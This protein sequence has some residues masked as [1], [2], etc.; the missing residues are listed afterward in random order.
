MLFLARGDTKA[1]QGGVVAGTYGTRGTFRGVNGFCFDAS[2]TV[3]VKNET[4][5]DQEAKKIMVKDVEEG[6]LIGT[7]DLKKS[8]LNSSA[9]I[10]TRVIDVDIFGGNWKAH[11]FLFASG[12][13][14]KVTS[15]HLMIIRKN[16]MWYFVRA[17]QVNV[18]DEMRVG[19][20]VEKVIKVTRLI[21]RSK[22]AIETEDGTIQVNE[23]LTSG[24]CDTIPKNLGFALKTDTALKEYKLSH[25]GE[26]FDNK[27]MNA[28][29]W[30]NAHIRNNFF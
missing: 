21:I 27:C 18:G 14:I 12:H 8:N 16:G 22:V 26:Y 7:M 19:Y 2:M 5:K 4:Q 30:K 25:F 20:L 24:L 1:T 11:N 29:A 23:V 17:D 6:Y 3:W 10:W 13:E 28:I 15:P 9:K